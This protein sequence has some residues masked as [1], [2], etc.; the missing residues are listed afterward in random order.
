MLTKKMKRLKS[1]NA[2]WWSLALGICFITGFAFFL[3]DAGW[4]PKSYFQPYDPDTYFMKF[5]I[6]TADKFAIAAS[7]TFTNTLLNAGIT[8]Y[9]D[10]YLTSNLYD[11]NVC[12]SSLRE[13]DELIQFFVLL[14]TIYKDLQRLLYVLFA[15]T[16]VYFVILQLV[17]KLL[18]ATVITNNFLHRKQNC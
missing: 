3:I 16:N 11:P 10:D 13:S 5:Q 4:F 17:A 9:V 8:A 12:R 1:F 18:A 14:Y 15:F 7:L 2:P 6:D